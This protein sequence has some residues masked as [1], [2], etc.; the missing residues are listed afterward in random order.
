[1]NLVERK[2]QLE[3]ELADINRKIERCD[4][5][6]GEI[7]YDPQIVK[8]PCGEHME[9]RGS[10]VWWAP[11]SYRDEKKDRWSKTCKKCGHKIYTEKT[12]PTG[13]KP[14]F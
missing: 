6:Y 5:E 2:E 12:V 3:R 9:T 7:Q 10:D 8:V 11:D 4:H 13:Y 14:V 1:M